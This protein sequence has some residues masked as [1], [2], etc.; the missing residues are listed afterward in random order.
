V[1]MR[2]REP[3]YPNVRC[4]FGHPDEPGYVVCV[5]V[6][7]GA[8]VAHLEEPTPSELGVVCC[9]VCFATEEKKAFLLTCATCVRSHGWDTMR[10]S[11]CLN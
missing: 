2:R 3:V 8:A 7:K 9:A 6:T 11:V 4:G 10:E 1:K 5:H